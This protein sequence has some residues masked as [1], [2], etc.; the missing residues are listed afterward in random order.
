MDTFSKANP[1]TESLIEPS[2]A[3]LEDFT[4]T[5]PQHIIRQHMNEGASMKTINTNFN[6]AGIGSSAEVVPL[7]MANGNQEP[8]ASKVQAYS[9]LQPQKHAHV[10]TL[11][12][13][14]AL[15]QQLYNGNFQHQQKRKSPPSQ[16]SQINL[17]AEIQDS[18]GILQQQHPNAN[19]NN[20]MPNSV[21][22]QS[23][24]AKLAPQQ[25]QRGGAPAENGVPNT[26]IT[27]QI[28]AAIMGDRG[29]VS[30]RQMAQL[31]QLQA[32]YGSLQ[33]HLS[34]QNETEGPQGKRSPSVS[35]SPGKT[36][37]VMTKL[38][39][40]NMLP[41]NGRVVDGFNSPPAALISS[42]VDVSGKH[43]G[44]VSKPQ[45]QNHI[46][47]PSQGNPRRYSLKPQ[48]FS[49]QSSQVTTP[50]QDSMGQTPVQQNFNL[51]P[52]VVG[53]GQPISA[54]GVVSHQQQQQLGRPRQQQQQ[55]QTQQHSQQQ[56]QHHF[57]PS[58]KYLNTHSQNGNQKIV[59]NSH[60][61]PRQVS[62]F[63]MQSFTS[64]YTTQNLRSDPQGLLNEEV[65]RNLSNIS[66][67]R[68]LRFHDLITCRH[69][70]PSL[71][72]LRHVIGEFFAE[73]ATFEVCL[74]YANES[75]NFRF[76][77]SLV[78]L[79][80]YKYLENVQMFELAQKFLNST[81]LPNGHTLIETD[82]FSF[83]CVFEDGSYCNHFGS[84]KIRVNRNLMF[85]KVELVTDYN[86]YGLEFA[87]LEKFLD[88]FA[89]Q[90]KPSCIPLSAQVKSYFRCIADLTKFGIEE[91]LLR[92]MQISDVMT[93]TKPLINFYVDSKSLSPLEALEAFNKMNFPAFQ[94]LSDMNAK[95]AGSRDSSS[96]TSGAQTVVGS[97]NETQNG[98]LNQ[99]MPRTDQF[100][101]T[102]NYNGPVMQVPANPMQYPQHAHTTTHVRPHR[103]S[104]SGTFNPRAVG[105]SN[106]NMLPS[107]DASYPANIPYNSINSVNG[108]GNNANNLN[109]SSVPLRKSTSE[110]NTITQVVSKKASKKFK[111]QAPPAPKAT[112]K[113]KVD[114]S[115]NDERNAKKTFIKK[116]NEPRN[117]GQKVNDNSNHGIRNNK[118]N[119]KLHETN[120]LSLS[121]NKETMNNF[122][123]GNPNTMDPELGNENK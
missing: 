31:Q 102:V 105:S 103:N 20:G 68:L 28:A 22:T 94:K 51:N 10:T 121:A 90:N 122:D 73:D 70:K 82:H 99:G 91:G 106:G 2:Q 40:E 21:R 52:Q 30:Q 114:S 26:T 13:S 63:P 15:P 60:N 55:Q 67:V 12:S 46:V 109:L 64:S 108:M 50:F 97:T 53:S 29:N 38:Q 34:K 42:M 11:Q 1:S 8:T 32:T 87:A 88:G 115:G 54:N 83:K 48:G 92:L 19:S 47:N 65:R 37:G 72:Y 116:E 57:N 117:S 81:L 74:K 49:S 118:E 58:A 77:Y 44:N 98:S 107:P 9:Q 18:Y 75:R 111:L 41:S 27:P 123:S 61:Q 14:T 79:L 84:L 66:I 71:P 36:F 93:L 120:G 16:G 3:G 56:S 96:E 119:N 33:T 112:K 43:T 100:T 95:I 69:E 5:N 39:G 104:I 78:P 25:N 6:Q 86:V 76:S 23:S 35:F 7:Q 113:R 89:G 62:Q 4:N 85:E 101:S 17:Q 24:Q 80:Y 110:G 59:S 45:L